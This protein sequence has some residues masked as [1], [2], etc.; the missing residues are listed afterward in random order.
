MEIYLLVLK[1]VFILTFKIIHL[2]RSLNKGI[3]RKIF[4]IFNHI[5][6]FTYFCVCKDMDLCVTVP[7]RVQKKT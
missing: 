2:N 6:L 7:C 5:Y 3:L 1:L 4:P